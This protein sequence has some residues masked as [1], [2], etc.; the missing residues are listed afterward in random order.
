MTFVCTMT[1]DYYRTYS[2]ILGC[3][4][5]KIPIQITGMV[6]NYIIQ[7]TAAM[8][9]GLMLTMFDREL[10]AVINKWLASNSMSVTRHNFSQ[11]LIWFLKRTTFNPMTLES[12]DHPIW[13]DIIQRTFGMAIVTKDINSYPSAK[14]ALLRRIQTPVI[15]PWR[16]ILAE[17]YIV[18]SNSL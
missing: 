7:L 13:D 17:F 2:A 6:K 4:I 5:S 12:R 8:K 11:S 10:R 1:S 9:D 16:T 18:L 15:A 14:R 3:G